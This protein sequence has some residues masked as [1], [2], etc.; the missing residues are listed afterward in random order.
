MITL[1]DIA[2]L[3][4]VSVNTACRA[5]KD[6]PDIGADTTRRVKQAAETL[7]YTPN[8][9][10]RGLVLKRSFT[11]GAVVTELSNPSRSML[12]QKLRLLA[13]NKGFHLLVSS[14]D[15]DDEVGDRIREMTSRA[16]DGLI[17]G[18]IDGI[19]AEKPYWPVLEMATKSG[20][21]VVLFFNAL[22]TKVDNVS[23]DYSMFT[24]QLTRHLIEAHRLKDILFVGES[25]DCPR[26]MGYSRA[27]NASG[28][29][30][31]I[32]AAPFG[33]WSVAETRKGIIE[34]VKTQ[35]PPKGIVCH[36]DLAAIGVIA[37]LR[38]AG[39]RV[40]EDVAVVG[41]DNIELA[42]YLNPR[43]TTI[44]VDPIKV[45][46]ALFGLLESRIAGTYSGARRQVKL[47]HDVFLRESCGCRQGRASSAKRQVRGRT[48]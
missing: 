8:V 35:R 7:G 25:L 47:T 3:T 9:M 28:L 24:E 36:N 14:Y 5:L 12:I 18:N 31:N 20:V 44:G 29:E 17:L 46:E 10:A 1:K 41:I 15:S 32:R 34:F 26:G 23:V 40:P 43:L 48:R 38:E 11:I 22:T 45:A 33:Y 2:K 6:M 16:V 39:W 37:G 42:D 21:P 19:L 4:G 13:L 30:R 27:M